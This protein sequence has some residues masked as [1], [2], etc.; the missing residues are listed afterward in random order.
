MTAIDLQALSPTSP[1][2][3]RAWQQRELPTTEEIAPG[4]WSIPVPIPDHPL[5][6]VISY[7]F[8]G[9]GR[10]VVVDPGWPT[11]ESWQALVEGLSRA[12]VGPEQVDGVLLTHGHHDHRG[13][14]GR[15]RA[16]SGAW[17]AVHPEE[18]RYLQDDPQDDPE[19][20]HRREEW[21]REAGAPA[22]AIAEVANSA[23]GLPA[24][25][26]PA[27]ANRLI[28]DGEAIDVP[29]G[30]RVIA[31]WTPGHSPGHLCFHLPQDR[32]LITGDH[33]LP[34]ISPNIS[35]F[36]GHPTSAL[37]DFLRSLEKVSALAVD[38]VLPAHEFRFDEF[39]RRV[40]ELSEHHSSRLI[41][42]LQVLSA[43]EASTGWGMA[44]QLSWARPWE[45]I[46]GFQKR[47]ALG[48]ALSHLHHLQ[49]TGSVS[50]H[51]VDGV[52]TW[53]PAPPR[54]AGARA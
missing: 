17:I 18:A 30:R 43:N 54:T 25:P 53:S 9:Q 2:Q 42:V 32:M 28:A 35:V 8:V 37:T 46:H 16:A 23:H 26:E 29:G 3:F 13:L 48:E 22:E 31:H 27:R 6:Y 20:A 24:M 21:M 38:H 1:A 39:T 44:S 50:S 12:G 14:A 45:Q 52:R 7:V 10:A 41:E 49:T 4:L 47:A 15:I 19:F 34:R 33:V 51:L 5:R 40:T 11:E 36:A